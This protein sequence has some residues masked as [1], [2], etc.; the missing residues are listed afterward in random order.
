MIPK[1]FL[2]VL[3]DMIGNKFFGDI[4]ITFQGGKIQRWSKTTSHLSPKE[5]SESPKTLGNKTKPGPQA[6]KLED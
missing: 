4:K 5:S 3:E 6:K 2:T 1:Y